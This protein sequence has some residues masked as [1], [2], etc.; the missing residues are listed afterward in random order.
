MPVKCSFACVNNACV[1]VEAKLIDR[2]GSLAPSVAVSES[3]ALK[4][5]SAPVTDKA[6]PTSIL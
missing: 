1:S 5:I 6:N 2:S 4:Q 3:L